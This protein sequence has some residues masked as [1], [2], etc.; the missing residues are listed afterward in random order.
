MNFSDIAKM[1]DMMG[2]ARQM[3]DQMEQRLQ[4]TV[5]EASSGGGMVTAKMNGKKELLALKIDPTAFSS[6]MGTPA[7]I[8]LLEDLIKAAINEAGRKADELIKQGVQSA[9]GGLNIP[10]LT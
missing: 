5:V 1:K 3:Q 4:Q 2:Q 10:G 7:D 9:L 8:E 6:G